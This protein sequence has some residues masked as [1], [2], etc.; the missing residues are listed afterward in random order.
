MTENFIKMK[1]LFMSTVHEAQDAN[2]VS[3][4]FAIKMK[5]EVQ[6]TTP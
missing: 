3:Q 6:Q 1:E 4:D 5:K 2:K